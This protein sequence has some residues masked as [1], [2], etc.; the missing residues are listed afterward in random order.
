ME[1]PAYKLSCLISAFSLLAPIPTAFAQQTPG[2]RIKSFSVGPDQTV[3][4]PNSLT[5]LP[6]EHTTFMPPASSTGP[7]LLFAASDI[8]GGQY[9]AVVLQSTD[10]KNFNFATALGYN[11]QVMTGPVPVGRCDPTDTTEF[12]GNYAAPGSVVQDPTLPAG[13]FIMN[14]EAENH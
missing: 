4:Y 1:I 10:L 8:S 3:S 13:N 11:S 14:Y 7:Y 9:G 2:L 6:D 12:D 5:G